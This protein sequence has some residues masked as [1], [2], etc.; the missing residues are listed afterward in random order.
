MTAFVRIHIEDKDGTKH[1]C[2]VILIAHIL[3]DKIHRLFEVTYPG[4]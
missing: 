4:W 2:M 1:E 3:G